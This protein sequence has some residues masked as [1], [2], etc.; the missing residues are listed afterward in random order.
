MLA[1]S[2]RLRQPASLRCGGFLVA[3]VHGKELVMRRTSEHASQGARVL[4]QPKMGVECTVG[5]RS[6]VLL[7]ESDPGAVYDEETIPLRMKM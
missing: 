3:S 4:G 6:C 7:K 5:D 1:D 2:L